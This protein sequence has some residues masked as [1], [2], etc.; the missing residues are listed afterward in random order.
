MDKRQQKSRKIIMSAF[1][2]LL[3]VKEIEKISMQEIADRANVNRGTIYLNFIDKYDLLNKCIEENFSDLVEECHTALKDK[4]PLT[5]DSLLVT[6]KYLENHF[7]FLRTLFKSIGFS[8]FRK[9]MQD[10]I[11]KGLHRYGQHKPSQ[12]GNG[13]IHSEVAL[14]FLASAVTGVL[15]WWFINDMPCTSEEIAEEL[16]SLLKDN[17]DGLL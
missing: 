12:N 6:F 7:E 16:W 5:K 11:I 17:L 4:K 14:Q 8:A 10:E 9:C 1:L 3:K 2:E 13:V 15:E